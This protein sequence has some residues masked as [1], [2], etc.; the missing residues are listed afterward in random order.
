MVTR[1]SPRHRRALAGVMPALGLI[2]AFFFL[3]LG[4]LLWRSFSEPT[5]GFEN[6]TKLLHDPTAKAILLR[7]FVVA[8]TITIATMMLGY[9]YAYI[10]TKVGRRFRTLLLA[11]VLIAFWNSLLAKSFAW[12]IILQD[13]G[14]LN[15]VLGALGLPQTHLLGTQA[16][17]TIGMIQVLLPFAILPL[18]A[19][20][21]GIDRS[22]V[23]AAQSLGARRAVAFLKVYLPLTVPGIMAGSL[24]VFVLSLG[25]YITPD[26]LGSPGN[27]LLS[28]LIGV[29]VETLLDFPGAGAMGASLLAITLVVIGIAAR[30]SRRILAVRSNGNA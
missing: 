4:L 14:P 24:L 15:T 28:Q 20:M 16:G 27:S 17:V 10:M 8:F 21:V 12:I 7:T 13:S 30:L 3:P 9:P 29:H 6:Y 11:I 23:P 25:F 26:L 2:G 1:Q 19:T 5:L 22:L 18:Y